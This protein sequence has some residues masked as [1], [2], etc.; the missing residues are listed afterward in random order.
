MQKRYY[1]IMNCQ[2]TDKRGNMEEKLGELEKEIRDLSSGMRVNNW[3]VQE[4]LTRN[5][6][7]IVKKHIKENYE[8]KKNSD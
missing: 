7:G 5:I 2:Q 8:I 3:L 4:V 1:I 6:I